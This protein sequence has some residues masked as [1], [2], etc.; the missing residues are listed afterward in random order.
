MRVDRAGRARA[1][2]PS[3]VWACRTALWAGIGISGCEAA[4]PA[5]RG[6][7]P[8]QILDAVPF[9]GASGRPDAAAATDAPQG[10]QVYWVDPGLEESTRADGSRARPYPRLEAAFDRARPGDVVALLPGDHPPLRPAGRGPPEGIEVLGSDRVGARL[11]GPVRLDARGVALRH[12][13]I[14]GGDP[15]L[16]VSAEV[17]V[18]DVSVVDAPGVGVAIEAGETRLEG[19][20]VERAGGVGLLVSGGTVAGSTL[21]IRGARGGGV[22]ISGGSVVLDDVAVGDVVLDVEGTRGNGVEVEGGDARLAGVRVD[23][24]ADRAVRIARTG[25]ATLSALEIVGPALDGLAILAGGF[26]EVDDFRIGGARN[27]GVAVSESGARLRRGTVHGGGRAAVLVS[28]SEIDVAGLVVEDASA[29]GVALLASEGTLADLTVRRAGDVGLQITDAV[30][31]TTI[32]DARFESCAGA[33]IAVQ[34]SLESVVRLERVTSDGATPGEADLAEGLHVYRARVEAADLTSTGNVGAGVL[35]E[36]GALSLNV[37]VLSGNGGPGIVAVAPVE[38][39]RLTDVEADGNA[40]AGVL[41]IGGVVRTTGLRASG[42]LVGPDGTADGLALTAGAVGTSEADVLVGNRGN[43]L[44]VSAGA[45]ATAR[46]L[47]SASNAG[48]GVYTQCGAG[49][50][51]LIEPRDLSANG[52]AERNVCP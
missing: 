37:G 8:T 47:T 13:T 39:V 9:D 46:L 10:P 52:A 21:E 29:R 44:S 31:P 42:T 19:L 18:E 11:A 3:A 43:G 25:R 24:V 40:G 4:A 23:A 50:A 2:H 20:R 30:G 34:G 49:R 22:R 14:V 38:A 12:L 26:A 36:E 15:A 28:G 45:A 16:A 35:V 1:T 51:T 5:A 6:P 27:V 32:S 41:V 7:G 48:F 17:R 33:G